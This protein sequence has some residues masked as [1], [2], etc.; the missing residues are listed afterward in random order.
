VLPD[1]VTDVLRRA[2]LLEPA[3]RTRSAPPPAAEL[4]GGVSSD[5]WR[6]DLPA[7][8]VCVKRARARLKVADAWEAPIERSDAEAAYLQ[9]VAPVV[10]G[11]V[12]RVLAHD[13]GAHVLVLEWLDP[14]THPVWKQHL[15]EGRVDAQVVEML[16]RIL[17]AIHATSAADPTIA[18]RFD[19]AAQFAALRLD[20]YL[21]AAA[22]A[23]PDL[24]GPLRA[25]REA[26]ESNRRVLVHGDVSPKNILVGPIGP[27][28]L[29]A[30]CATF[31]DASFD[32]AFCIN[33]LLLKCAHRPEATAAY[34]DGVA[35][36]SA[37]YVTGISWEP[38]ELL[39]ARTAAL[40][41][42]LALARIDGKSPVDYL[43]EAARAGVRQLAR[44]LLA[45]PPA[46]LGELAERWQAGIASWPT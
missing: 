7:G 12:P 8:P 20:P 26:I 28:L 46:R 44:A 37:A 41:P 22:R 39:E 30:E 24:A 23:H 13:P 6:V 40:V 1:D 14:V 35:R 36:L 5:I 33:H 25:R 19:N 10:L 45:A 29:D 32:L 27:V 9:E 16:G 15:L 18:T 43:D 42:A 34:L 4:S 2:G 17:A 21:E 3:A 11:H 38:A 31:G